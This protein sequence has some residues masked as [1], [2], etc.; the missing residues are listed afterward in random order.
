MYSY[1]ESGTINVYN[2]LSH[3]R[4]NNIHNKIR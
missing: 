2:Y 1:Y 3:L 4:L